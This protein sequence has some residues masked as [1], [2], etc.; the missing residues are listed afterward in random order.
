MTDQQAVVV[1]VSDGAEASAG[2]DQM[3]VRLHARQLADP[4]D[5]QR[6]GRRRL[7][8]GRLVILEIGRRK[9]HGR[10]LFVEI[11]DRF[12]DVDLEVVEF[13][14]VVA[15]H[16]E[17]RVRGRGGG[18]LFLMKNKSKVFFRKQI[19]LCIKHLKKFLLSSFVKFVL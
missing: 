2:R 9:L 11:V 17:E 12:S 5:R 7:R 8:N 16:G 18:F 3:V 10:S 15:L 4:A 6:Q 19:S 1:N 13:E 14:V